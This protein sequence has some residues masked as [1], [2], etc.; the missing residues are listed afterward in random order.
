[1]AIAA[2]CAQRE[3]LR[4]LPPTQDI[5]CIDLPTY[6]TDIL[7]SAS[8]HMAPHEQVNSTPP[9]SAPRYWSSWSIQTCVG[10]TQVITQTGLLEFKAGSAERGRSIFEGVLRNYPKRLDLWSV[11][12]DQVTLPPP[13][14]RPDTGLLA[15]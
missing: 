13:S 10:P 8:Y 5:T 4:Y 7:H 12:L 2:S 9:S 6:T 11:Y 1:M 3:N 15:M 14:G